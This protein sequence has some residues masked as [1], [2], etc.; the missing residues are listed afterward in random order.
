MRRRCSGL[1]AASVLENC[2]DELRHLGAVGRA[3]TLAFAAVLRLASVVTGLAAALSLA[4]VLALTGMLGWLVCIG[5]AESGLGSL[6]HWIVGVRARGGRVS[7]D[8]S[9]HQTSESSREQHC[10][11]LVLHVDRPLWG[12]RRG[13]RRV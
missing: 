2:L 1:Y 9:T 8:G 11:E 4:I 3:A 6:D 10:T 7:R 12:L 13:S 5:I